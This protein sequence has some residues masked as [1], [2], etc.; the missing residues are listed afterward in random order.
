MYDYDLP[1]PLPICDV[2]TSRRRISPAAIGVDPTGRRAI[3]QCW[4]G[5]H[6]ACHRSR[7]AGRGRR[8]RAP[9][10]QRGD[11]QQYAASRDPA[12]HLSGHALSNGCAGRSFGQRAFRYAPGIATEA[13]GGVSGYDELTIRGFTSTNDMA[14]TFLDGL[15]MGEGL[16]FGSQQVDAFLLER[17]EVLRGPASVLYGRANPGGVVVLTSK[18]PRDQAI[19]RVELEGARM[20]TGALPST[21]AA[22]PMR[23][24]RCCFALSARP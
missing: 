24:A 21:W 5:R 1:I 9:A 6:V 13:W 2:P 8:P 12:V 18:L 19:R 16:V 20:A 11:S 22:R 17:M 15:R 10:R 4:R 14:D 3:G 23:A 7:R